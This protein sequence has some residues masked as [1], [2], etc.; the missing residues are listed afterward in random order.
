MQQMV[1]NNRV[2]VLLKQRKQS[3]IKNKLHENILEQFRIRK[4][5]FRNSPDR[6]E[7]T[8]DYNLLQVY[9]DSIDTQHR[10]N[11]IR[12]AS[13][14]Q[15]KDQSSFQTSSHAFT[16]EMFEQLIDENE[17]YLFEP[18]DYV[19]TIHTLGLI[20]CGVIMFKHRIWDQAIKFWKASLPTTPIELKT[21]LLFNI[22]IG[23]F[24]D[25]RF[26][27]SINSTQDMIRELCVFLT[28]DSNFQ[29]EDH[30]DFIG[31]TKINDMVERCNLLFGQLTKQINE[32]EA[33]V[34]IEA[35]KMEVK[36][37]EDFVEPKFQ[38]NQDK[39]EKQ[40]LESI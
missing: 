7:K 35:K 19:K 17:F 33:K 30:L 25:G 40:T 28:D 26:D 27:L 14:N 32:Q 21:Q 37:D 36:F 6:L 5:N 12:V 10:N 11:E 20:N 15:L 9:Q 29:D 23:Y 22:S 4:P 2:S 38:S 8:Q 13:T 34:Q 3:I 39:F 18:L 1:L 16:S 24:L 31:I